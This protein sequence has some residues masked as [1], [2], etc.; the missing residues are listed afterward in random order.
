M[1]PRANTR[2]Q[3]E[4]TILL[5]EPWGELLELSGSSLTGHYQP[6]I[7]RLT[8]VD[9]GRLDGYPAP[10]QL[11]TTVFSLSSRSTRIYKIAKKLSLLR[12]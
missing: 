7:K 8:C 6:G 9:N 1:P 3:S 4:L 12:V 10:V 5:A 11:V 2:Q